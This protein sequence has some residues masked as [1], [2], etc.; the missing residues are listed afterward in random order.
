FEDDQEKIKEFYRDNGYIDFEIK[1]IQIVNPTPKTMEIRFLVYEGTQYKVGSIKFSGNKLFTTNEITQ[2]LQY[3]RA[4]R[5]S[6]AKLGVHGLEMDVGDVFKPKGYSR[7]IEQI[8]DFYGAKG[9]IDVT[10]TS[11]HLI[12]NKIPNTETGTM[13]LEFILDEG[14]KAY[15]EKIEIR[16]NT[17]TKDRVIRRE[18]AVS[19]GEVFD[20]VRVKVSKS[21]LENLQYFEKVDARP[22]PTEVPNRKNLIIGVD[23]KNTGNLTMGAGFSS[24]DSIVGF[25]EVS[26]GNFDLFH[27]PTFT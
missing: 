27:P 19:P 10:A 15:V 20:M 23:E 24:V 7:D 16:G 13:D 22:E 14:Q 12:V 6:R 17:K 5:G 25:V 8:E 26:Q 9:Y 3:M 11:R 18:L 1:D 21:R 2:G 4:I